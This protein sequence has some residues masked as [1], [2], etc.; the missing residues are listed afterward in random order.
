MKRSLLTAKENDMDRL[1][2]H[3]QNRLGSLVRDLRLE[4]SERGLVIQGNAHTYYGKQLALQ[5]VK[6]ASQIPI[7]ANEIVVL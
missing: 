4:T 7:L 6:E 1:Q 5:Y 2:M 3:V